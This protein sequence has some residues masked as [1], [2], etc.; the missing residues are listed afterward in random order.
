MT[1]NFDSIP[2]PEL[3]YRA[4]ND[5]DEALR[6]AAIARIEDKAHRIKLAIDAGVSPADFKRLN[7]VHS[8]LEA[9]GNL[10]KALWPVAK[11]KRHKG[12]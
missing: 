7:T 9:S 10:I 4:M 5:D 6:D 2:S 12:D 11:A 3:I 8:A 1:D